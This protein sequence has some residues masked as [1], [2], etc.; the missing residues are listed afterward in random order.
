ML[1]QRRLAVQEVPKPK[2]QAGWVIVK[3]EASAICGSDLHALY[4]R[5]EATACT[6]GHET[7]GTVVEVGPECTLQ[8]GTRVFIYSILP[9]TRCRFCLAGD[10]PLC[11]ALQSYGFSL[12]GGDAEYVHV[13]ERVCLPLPDDISFEVGT[14]I[15]DVVGVSLHQLSRVHTTAEDTV[16]LFGLGPMGLGAVL[17]AKYFGAAVIA[18]EPSDYRR[19][20]AQRLGADLLLDPKNDD[21]RKAVRDFT[22]NRGASVGVEAAARPDT[23]RMLLELASRA[24]RICLIGEQSE[25]CFN[26]SAHF[27]RKALTMVGST[28]FLPAEF[29]RAIALVRRMPQTQEIIT[30]RFPLARAGEAFELFASGN[31]GKVVLLGQ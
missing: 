1:G 7:T 21:V 17:V 11:E 4:E 23:L 29:D 28:Y 3:M 31:T 30:H 10:Y 14:L 25:A 13:A 2:R 20:I 19:A 5:G 9:C 26:P 15:G 24:G 12:D 22:H 27:L 18:V 8:L 6:P 16:L